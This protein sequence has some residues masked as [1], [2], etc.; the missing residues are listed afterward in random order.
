[1]A[2]VRTAE[3]FRG[4]D[5]IE[6]AWCLR[7]NRGCNQR[8]MRDFFAA[9]SRLGDGVFWYTLIMLLPAVYGEP[10]L[11]PAIRMAIVGIHRRRAVQVAEV[12]AGPRTTVY[13]AGGHRLRA[14]ERSI[15]TV[16]RPATRCTR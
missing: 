5:A 9:V 3:L 11:Y 15:A 13:F 7:L 14:R 6:H 1:M 10:A 8:A 16:S 12:A 2:R 4:S